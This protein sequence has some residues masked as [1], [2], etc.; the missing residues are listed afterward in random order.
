[1]R[2]HSIALSHVGRVRKI[3]EDAYLERPD[4]G[5]WVVADGMGGHAAGDVASEMIVTAMAKVRPAPDLSTFVEFAEHQLLTTNDR[6]IALARERGQVIGSTVV[7]LLAQ[8]D[9]CAFLWAGDSR[10]YRWRAGTLE[11]LSTDHSKVEEYVRMGLVA[12]EDAHKHPDG[13]L[14][15]RAVGATETLHLECNMARLAPGDRFL[16]CSDG[17]DKHVPFEDIAEGMGRQSLAR[18]A[19]HLVDLTLEYGASDNVTVCLVEVTAD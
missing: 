5:L 14:I 11:Q 1:M 9:Y 15:T 4:Y 10:L 6:L 3:N 2:W 17:L 8:G 19:R 18:I 13:N 16:L 12:R 7:A